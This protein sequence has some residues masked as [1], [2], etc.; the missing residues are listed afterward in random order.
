MT[1]IGDLLNLQCMKFLNTE[2]VDQSVIDRLKLN[3]FIVL[4]KRPQ[5]DIHIDY[6][7]YKIFKHIVLAVIRKINIF[8]RFVQ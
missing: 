8:G 1:K 7:I 3:A 6:G 2:G 4:D 5:K